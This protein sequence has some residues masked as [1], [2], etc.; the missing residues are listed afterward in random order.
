MLTFAARAAVRLQV[1]CIEAE[2]RNMG[3]AWQTARK[4][5]HEDER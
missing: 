1:K 4:P 3:A 2:L 5:S